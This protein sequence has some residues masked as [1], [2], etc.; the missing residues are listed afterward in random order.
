MHWVFSILAYCWRKCFQL[1][2][3]G[4]SLFSCPFRVEFFTY[5]CLLRVEVLIYEHLPLTSGSLFSCPLWVE[6]FPLETCWGKSFHLPFAG[7]GVFICLLLEE[8]FSLASGS[9]MYFHLH[10]LYR[11]W[12]HLRIPVGSVFTCV[13]YCWMKCFHFHIALGSVFT[14]VLLEE[15]FSLT[16]CWRKF[17][18]LRIAGGSFFTYVLPEKVFSLEYCWRKCLQDEGCAKRTEES[19]L[20]LLLL[21]LSKMWAVQGCRE[22]DIHPI[23]P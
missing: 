19:L 12:L 8:V 15:V 20:L 21:W 17:F 5:T 6:V 11:K 7:R 23:S 18:H 10:Q 14:C 3:A 1:P 4:G 9:K 13:S 16:Y 22:S 2:L